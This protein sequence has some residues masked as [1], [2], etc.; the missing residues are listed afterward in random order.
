MVLSDALVKSIRNKNMG[1]D[2]TYRKWAIW[3]DKKNTHVY[4]ARRDNARYA[5]IESRKR[6]I[7]Y[8]RNMRNGSNTILKQCLDKTDEEPETQWKTEREKYVQ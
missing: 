2:C 7:K 5:R 3:L 8:K 4:N 6:T 1:M